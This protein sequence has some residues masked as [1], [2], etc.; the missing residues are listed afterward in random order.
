[1]PLEDFII[2]VYCMVD[3]S[4]GHVLNGRRLRQRGFAPALSD[5]EVLTM[6]LVGAYLGLNEEEALWAYFHRHW[7]PWFPA[8]ASRTAFTRQAANLWRVKATLQERW[9][10]ELGVSDWPVH[11]VDGFPLPVC[12]FRRARSSHC[13]TG[14]A[15]FGYCAA[16]GLFYYGFK[17]LLV[18]DA[19]GAI[20]RFSAVPA[21]VDERDALEALDLAPLR[22]L[23][24]GDKGFLRPQLKAGLAAR[25]LCLQTPV[26]ANM[27][28]ARPAAFLDWMS[29]QRRLIETVIAQL[30]GRFQIQA[31]RARDLWH[32]TSRL[33]RKLAAHTLCALINWQ[34]GRSLLDFDNI[35]TA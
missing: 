17:G 12:H 29:Q 32:L 34:D 14:E 9:A 10:N 35:V 30:S 33:Y 26:R 20:A 11:V 31:N 4:L 24:L 19:R 1:M 5:A 18:V 28:E 21:N 2:R 15:A 7:R 13:F 25:G 16:K 22:G 8:L 3:E 23:L 6:E 27:P